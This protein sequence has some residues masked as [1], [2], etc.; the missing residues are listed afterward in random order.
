MS[1]SLQSQHKAYSA[2]EVMH[3]PGC[4]SLYMS[5]LHATLREAAEVIVAEIALCSQRR[6]KFF[7]KLPIIK[8][9]EVKSKKEG[10]RTESSHEIMEVAF[11]GK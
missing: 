1:F 8:D 10:Y 3:R 6:K 9:L 4:G 7:I 5:L 2:S 11:E